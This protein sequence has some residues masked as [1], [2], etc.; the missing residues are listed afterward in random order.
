MLSRLFLA[1]VVLSLCTVAQASQTAWSWSFSG[2]VFGTDAVAVDGLDSLDQPLTGQTFVYCGVYRVRDVEGWNGDSGFYARDTRSPLP[3]LPGQS[4][5]WVFFLWQDPGYN[6]WPLQLSW[7]QNEAAD[8]VEYELT[9]DRAAQGITSGDVALG[10]RISLNG[11]PH[12]AWTFPSYRAADGRTGYMFTL[13]AT[14]IP[15]PSTLAA[16]LASLAG[17]GTVMRRRRRG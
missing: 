11:Q 7:S 13:T 8:R 14:V 1:A 16:V 17:F 9:Y 5:T 12:G 2:A 4:K 10:T 15:E 3:R 6:P